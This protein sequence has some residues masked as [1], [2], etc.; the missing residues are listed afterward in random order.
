MAAA[1]LGSIDVEQRQARWSERLSD[2]AGVPVRVAVREG[3][4]V[5]FCLVAAPSRDADAGEDVAEIAA[6][7]VSPDAWGC[8]VGTA[9]V[10]DALASLKRDG[11]R[12]VSLWVVDGNDRA[13]TFYERLGFRLDGASTTH[14]GSGARELRMTMALSDADGS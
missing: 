4:I 5:G 11:W 1:F 13:R 12:T 7:N 10:H 9:L 6:L 3:A 2:D 14:E 8:G